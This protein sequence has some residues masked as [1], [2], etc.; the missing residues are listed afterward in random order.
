MRV[1]HTVDRHR[2]ELVLDRECAVSCYELD[3]RIGDRARLQRVWL[4]SRRGREDLW[5]EALGTFAH[6]EGCALGDHRASTCGMIDV[7][8]RDHHVADL[9]ARERIADPGQQRVA[10]RLGERGLEE[11]QTG[12]TL[13]AAAS[14]GEPRATCRVAC[15]AG[16]G[17]GPSPLAL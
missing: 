4:D 16:P 10:T 2:S 11:D 8:V 15:H 5:Q 7:D 14:V 9:R 3:R 1:G 6:E 17:L 13:R 12:A